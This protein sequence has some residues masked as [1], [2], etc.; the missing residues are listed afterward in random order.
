MVTKIFRLSRPLLRRYAHGSTP[1][2]AR[3][4]NIQRACKASFEAVS[5]TEVI[6]N[7]A[8]ASVAVVVRTLE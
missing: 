3:N 4:I 7:F 5:A 8:V 6:L 2:E 1:N